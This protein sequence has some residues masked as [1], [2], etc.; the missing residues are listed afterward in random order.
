[1]RQRAFRGFT[2]VELMIALAIAGILAAAALPAYMDYSVR[3][4]VSE[5]I[6]L[7]A[8]ARR[9]VVENA[10][11][12]VTLL[13]EAQRWNAQ[14]AG[15]GVSSKYV[16]SVLI[17]EASG[18]VTVTFDEIGAGG[19]SADATLI[20][21]PY[22]RTVD[23]PVALGASFAIFSAEQSSIDWG[24]ASSTNAVSTG[25]GLP[26]LTAATLPARFSPAECR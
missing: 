10:G 11:T 26:A 23:G 12:S 22:V 13:R 20:Y 21:T 16:K 4:R 15:K 24:C 25:H 19:S 5:G 2:T 6:V 8:D 9:R 7:A 17:N 14:A 3:A 1:M 18:E